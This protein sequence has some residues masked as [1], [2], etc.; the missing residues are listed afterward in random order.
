MATPKRVG[1]YGGSFSPIHL[2][3]TAL[4]Q[5]LIDNDYVDE[6]WLMVS[7]QNPLKTAHFLYPEALRIEMAE[8]ATAHLPQVKVSDF[9]CHL[10]KPT[11]T[12]KTLDALRAAYPDVELALL[13]GGDNWLLFDKWR[14]SE[15]LL[16]M[17]S[18][19]VY[20]RP[21]YPISSA[22]I[23]KMP[24][25]VTY[26]ADAP[27]MNMSSTEIREVFEQ[28]GD[29]SDKLHPSVEAKLRTYSE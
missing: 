29:C 4:A 19:L 22:E 24:S 13:V 2:A 12:V 1:I 26:L 7:P 20:P 3:H 16:T 28:G 25:M 10:P 8:L 15:R 9:E 6:V 18:L 21:G 23:A 17:C 27:Q 5:Y 14:E 11:Y